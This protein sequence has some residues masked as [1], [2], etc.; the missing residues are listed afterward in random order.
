MD[1]TA[2]G[3]FSSDGFFQS[4]ENLSVASPDYVSNSAA[5]L[6]EMLCEKVKL[7]EYEKCARIR[8]ELRRRN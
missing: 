6:E 2:M 5:Q 7:E 3:L 1:T 4:F 8:D